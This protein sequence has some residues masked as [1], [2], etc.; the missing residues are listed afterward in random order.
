M[1]ILHACLSEAMQPR[2]EGASGRRG[3]EGGANVSG[4]CVFEWVVLVAGKNVFCA[5]VSIHGRGGL[6]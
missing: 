2:E 1:L 4:G 3:G 5:C 6:P